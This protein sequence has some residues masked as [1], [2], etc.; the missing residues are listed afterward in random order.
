MMTILCKLGTSV[1]WLKLEWGTT[2]SLVV[3]VRVSAFKKLGYDRGQAGYG[4]LTWPGHP[5][6]F[7]CLRASCIVPAV[8]VRVFCAQLGT[9]RRNMSGLS[10]AEMWARDKAHVVEGLQGYTGDTLPQAIPKALQFWLD[11][12]REPREQ[13]AVAFWLAATLGDMLSTPSTPCV[14]GLDVCVAELAHA[15]I[16]A[17]REVAVTL[18]VASL[19]A[20]VVAWV[21]QHPRV[22]AAS[23]SSMVDKADITPDAKGVQRVTLPL[24]YS[25]PIGILTELEVENLL[26]YTCSIDVN[27]AFAGLAKSRGMH[28]AGELRTVVPTRKRMRPHIFLSRLRRCTEGNPEVQNALFRACLRLGL[29]TRAGAVVAKALDLRTHVSSVYPFESQCILVPFTDYVVAAFE[30]Y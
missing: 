7:S 2:R 22:V 28:A 18:D 30:S 20:R 5:F 9:P 17:E 26:L 8:F 24:S 11:S 1:P 25:Q 16:D 21:L 27:K 14:F 15:F 29:L 10:E 19:N 23:D 6:I 12:I 4:Y 3:R 13:E